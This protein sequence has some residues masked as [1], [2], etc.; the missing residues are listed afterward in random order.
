MALVFGD[1]G[2]DGSESFTYIDFATS[3]RNFVDTFL[4]EGVDFVF[5]RRKNFRNFGR[6]FVYG[7]DVVFL[8]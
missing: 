6:R 7:L 5:Y 4:G 3:A 8:E 2:V 1:S